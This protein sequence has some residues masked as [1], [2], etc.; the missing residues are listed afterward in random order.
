MTR[1]KYILLLLI[2]FSLPQLGISQQQEDN[3]LQKRT[4]FI[5]GIFWNF[6]G[7]NL[8][9]RSWSPKYNRFIIDVKYHDLATT[10]PTKIFNTDW[11]SIGFNTQFIFDI[12]WNKS[13]T[14]GLGIGI[15]YEFGKYYHQLAIKNTM[16]IYDFINEASSQVNKRILR[17]HTFFIPIEM[18]FRTKGYRHFKFH[19]GSNIGYR[20]GNEKV[21]VGNETSRIKTGGMDNFEWLMLDLHARIGIRNWGIIVSTN[22]LPIFRKTSV[23]TYPISLGISISLF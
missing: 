10:N 7:L 5:P 13:N 14:V 22:M 9:K 20:F 18:R 12:P 2:V 23:K 17:T 6:T 15:G 1:L 4:E 11:K 21:N 3:N 19:I 8:P 16:N